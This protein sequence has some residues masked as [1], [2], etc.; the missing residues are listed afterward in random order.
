MSTISHSHWGD[1][2]MPD[3]THVVGMIV[4]RGDNVLM[5]STRFIHL[6]PLEMK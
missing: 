4:T 2:F 3:V 1:D 5:Q 6:F